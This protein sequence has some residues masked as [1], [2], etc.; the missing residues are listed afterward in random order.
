[1]VTPNTIANMPPIKYIIGLA[2]SFT[3]EKI[4]PIIEPKKETPEDKADRSEK[5]LWL[6]FFFLILSHL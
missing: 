1:M 3:S 5:D 4:P 2:I 6:S